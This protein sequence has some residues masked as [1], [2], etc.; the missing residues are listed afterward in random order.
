MW[1]RIPPALSVFAIVAEL[2]DAQVEGLVSQEVGVRIPPI[3]ASVQRKRPALSYRVYEE[4]SAR[5]EDAGIHVLAVS[6]NVEGLDFVLRQE[7]QELVRL[8][9]TGPR[10]KVQ[11]A[12]GLASHTDGE[13]APG[14]TRVPEH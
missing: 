3:A 5:E 4:G 9:Y 13:A 10:L 1:V 14:R 7:S 12:A 8:R 2:V 6:R 11:R